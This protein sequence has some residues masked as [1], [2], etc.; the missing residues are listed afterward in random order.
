VLADDVFDFA[1]SLSRNALW[2]RENRLSNS[3]LTDGVFWGIEITSS[4]QKDF[5]AISHFYIILTLKIAH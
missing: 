4:T 2:Y 5:Y 1:V 3:S